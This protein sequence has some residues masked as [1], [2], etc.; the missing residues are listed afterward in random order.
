M[1][2]SPA[3]FASAQNSLCLRHLEAS[4]CLWFGYASNLHLSKV[5]ES[6]F[7]WSYLV[8]GGALQSTRRRQ[9][10]FGELSSGQRMVRVSMMRKEGSR[11]HLDLHRLR[12]GRKGKVICA[13]S[14]IRLAQTSC[15]PQKLDDNRIASSQ[16]KGSL[17]L[18]VAHHPR[19]C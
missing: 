13:G 12:G 14:R 11:P 16:R 6:F 1:V 19:Q 8:H 17:N 2:P 3:Y 15:L 4:D 9:Q 18:T 7:V 5:Q 10:W